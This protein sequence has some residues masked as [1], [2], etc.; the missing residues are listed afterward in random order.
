M[1]NTII[2]DLDGTL[3]IIDESRDHTLKMGKNG[4]MNWNEFFNPI[5]C[6]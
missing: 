1:K 3:I 6:I 4:K 2:F 5:I